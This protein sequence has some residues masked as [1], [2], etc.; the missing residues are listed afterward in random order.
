MKLHMNTC[1]SL[2]VILV[3]AGVRETLSLRQKTDTHNLS[4]E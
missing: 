1:T 3:A 2:H 4:D